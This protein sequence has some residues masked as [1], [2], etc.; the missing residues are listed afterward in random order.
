MNANE[1][2]FDDAIRHQI[3]LQ[4]FNNRQVKDMLA[5]LRKVEKRVLS[6][7]LDPQTGY[8][9]ARLTEILKTVRGI[10]SE[11]YGGITTATEEAMRGLAGHEAG[12]QQAALARSVP[13]DIAFAKP[14]ANQIWA[15]VTTRPFSGKIMSEW[16]S[17]ME[18]GAYR[19]MKDTIRLGYVDGTPT[20]KIIR[21]IRGTKALG[22]KD[23]IN[24]ANRRGLETAVRTAVGHSAAA[25]RMRTIEQNDDVVKGVIWRSTL[26]TRTSP[27][28]RPRDG[29]K[30]DTDRKPIGHSYTW[31]GG[32]GSAHPNCRSTAIPW[33]KSWKEMGIDLKEAP[34][35]TRASM[36]GQVSADMDY[37]DWLRGQS[38][39][40]QDQAL[41]PM[42]GKL[43]R[44]G[45][46]SVDRFQ[47]NT[48]IEYTLDQLQRRDAEAWDKAFD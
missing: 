19:R 24:G 44:D 36:N 10:M 11:G 48:G 4:G 42:R 3:Y 13:L 1:Q 25:A 35:G 7:L 39:K 28:C 43:F 38:A 22:Y 12:W 23:G 20:D 32:A 14:A 33:L 29:K 30:Y 37:G 27:I 46:L 18:R 15:A 16:F 5:M 40:V 8:G 2:L 31:L 26:D 17:D 41:G 45:G 21:Q 34:E 6:A 47:N 9:E